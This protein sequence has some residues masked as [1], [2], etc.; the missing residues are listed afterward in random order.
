M[1]ATDDTP[2]PSASRRPSGVV[3]STRT[4][5]FA[6]ALAM[7]GTVGGGGLTWAASGVVPPELKADVAET[8]ADVAELKA[9]MAQVQAALV[10]IEAAA[11]GDKLIHDTLSGTLRDH[12][13]RLRSMERRLR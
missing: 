3:I 11:G 4:L 5:L 6:G 12:E 10:R 1:T 13:D 9:T 2:E 7:G 8:K